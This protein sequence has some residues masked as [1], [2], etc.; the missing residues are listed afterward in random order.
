MSCPVASRRL[1]DEQSIV[2]TRRLMSKRSD[3][4]LKGRA[5]SYRRYA[6]NQSISS[7]LPLCKNSGTTRL[8]LIRGKFLTVVW[9]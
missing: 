3:P 9:L 5:K 7:T 8:R 4:G 6:S 1:R 2:A